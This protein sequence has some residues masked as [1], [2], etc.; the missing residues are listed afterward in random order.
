MNT[1]NFTKIQAVSTLVSLLPMV[2]Y[3]IAWGNL[4]AQMQV[5]I[6]P[7]PLYLPRAVAAIVIPIALAIVHLILTFVIRNHVIKENKPNTIWLCWLL[8][9]ISILANIPLLH[10]N[11]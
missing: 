9:V 1:S 10:V 3:L 6:M 2:V 4:P 11:I 7:D 8:P 5:N